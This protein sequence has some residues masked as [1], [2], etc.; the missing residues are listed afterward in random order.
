MAKSWSLSYMS[1]SHPMNVPCQNFTISRVTSSDIGTK[2]LRTNEVKVMTAK[3]ALCTYVK[4]R[5]QVHVVLKKS[6]PQV[7]SHLLAWLMPR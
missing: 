3:A 4:I 5:I 2:F 6:R 7:L 1:T